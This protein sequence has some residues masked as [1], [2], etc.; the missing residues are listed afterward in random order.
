ME[1]V[2]PTYEIAGIPFIVDVDYSLLRHPEDERYT[3]SFLND[4]EDKGSHY[5]LYMDKTTMEPAVYQL[6]TP[7]DG[8]TLIFNIPQMVQLDPEGVAFK[9]GIAPNMLPEKDIDCTMNPEVFKKREMGQLSV[10]DICGHPFFIDVRNGLLQPKDDFTTMGI[11]LSKLEVDDS[12][13][14]YLCLYDPQ[15]HTTVTLDPKIKKIPRGIVALQIPSE[16]ILDSYAVA[17]QYNLLE[18]T[19]W[20]RKFPVR[21]NLS[22]RIIPWEKTSLPELV[23][24]NKTK[25]KTIN[26]R[27]GKGKGL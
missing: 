4:L 7:D 12:G 18:S 22:A 9:Y 6:R 8:N 13:T 5:D 26:K 16:T 10:I 19:D 27:N 21:T 23:E 17:R 1:R 25:Q 14:A 15:K 3:I 11:E 20:F 2:L 24:R